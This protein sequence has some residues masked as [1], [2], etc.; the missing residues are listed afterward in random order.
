MPL[1]NSNP[2]KTLVL[3]L[4][5]F[6]STYCFW[7][8]TQDVRE[9]A[10]RATMTIFFIPAKL[11]HNQ[12]IMAG[13]L[14]RLVKMLDA[15]KGLIFFNSFYDSL[16]GKPQHFSV[17]GNGHYLFFHTANIGNSLQLTI[18]TTSPYHN[19]TDRENKESK[20]V[21]VPAYLPATLYPHPP[22]I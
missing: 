5:T 6:P 9:A 17:A 8:V 10:I 20:R 21:S 2:T 22:D 11:L 4:I 14:P 7:M 19:K 3:S 12:N 1:R 18:F 16:S 13:L 15:R